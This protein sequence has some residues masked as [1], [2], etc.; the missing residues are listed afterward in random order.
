MSTIVHPAVPDA[1][2]FERHPPGLKVIFFTEMWER[3]SYYGMRA[4]LVLYLV[5]ALHYDRKDALELYGIYT[6]LV[7]LTPLLGGYL[8]DKYLGLRQGAVIGGLIMMLGHFAMAFEPLLHLALGL[9]ILGNGFFKPNT[10]TMVGQLYREHD[11]RRDGGYTIFYMGINLGAFFSPLVAGTLG[12]KLGWH[13]GFAS[14]GVGMAIGVFTLLRWQGLLGN[15][16]LRAGQ[17]CIDRRDWVRILAFTAAAIPTVLGTI[18]LWG[19]VSGVIAP[20]PLLVKLLLGFAVIGAALWIPTRFGSVDPDAKPLTRADWDAILAICI[21]CFFVIFFWMGF[22]QAGGTMNLFADQQTDRH[23]FGFEIP[24]SWFQS[25]NPLV[26]VLLAPA[27]SALWTRLDRTRFALSV[28]AKQ[29]LGMVVLG[30]GFI[31]L[32][33]AQGRAEKFGSVGPHWLF[34]VYFLHTIGELMLSPVGLS[35]VSK[36][37]PARFAGLLMGVWMLSSAVANYLSG[38]LEAMLAGSGVPLYW[39]LVGS[40]VGAGLVLLALTPMLKK[41]MHGRD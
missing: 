19:A 33:I 30:L 8:A 20:L 21:V 17:T 27:F 16:G 31:V 22:E 12:E 3:F 24:A 29:A 34:I 35:M 39:F 28:S 2:E 32:A 10:S 6:G 26:I 5:N 1:D 40:S 36:L 7:Y 4:L 18:A 37:A 23:A 25:I 14:A 11:P 9:L 38:T 15:A 41:L 13:W